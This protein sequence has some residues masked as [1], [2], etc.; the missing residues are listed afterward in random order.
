LG[1]AC[2]CKLHNHCRGRNWCWWR[3]DNVGQVTPPVIAAA[4]HAIEAFGG[5]KESK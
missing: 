1:G 5:Q 4:E 2:D 3:K